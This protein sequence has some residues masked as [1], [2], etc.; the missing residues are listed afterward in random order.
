M[1]RSGR[2]YLALFVAN[3]AAV[4]VFWWLALDRSELASAAGA[5]NAAGRLAA[6]VGTYLLLVQLALR[7]HVPWLVAAF[8][9]DPLKRLHTWNAY[10]AV[11]LIAAHVVLQ[12][13]GYALQERLGLSDE[14][15]VMLGYE[16]LVPAIV[17]SLLLG[18]LTIVAL[19]RFRHQMAWPTWRA[20]HLFTY[21]AVALSI[22]HILATGS[23]FIDAPGWAAYW[24]AVELG[25]VVVLLAARVPPMWR[26]AAAAGRPHPAIVAVAAVV[27]ATY[28]FGTVRMTFASAVASPS[29]SPAGPRGTPRPSPST[30]ARPTPTGALAEASLVV[31]GEVIDT[32]YGPLQVRLV[33]AGGRVADV[34]PVM[35]PSA[36]KR[37]H[38]ISVSVEP[39]LRKRAVA[40]QSADFEILSGA[41]YTS[42]AY[43][44]SLES[45]LRASGLEQP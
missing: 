6:L 16:G 8:G 38:T 18:A 41:T 29:A 23:D 45:A 30:T 2:A 40:A 43:Q 39:W 42:R 14:I 19:D 27:L 13:A 17:G 35:L 28:L 10:L 34:E 11:G 25:V 9:K 44:A 3:L 12:I 24:V 20:L 1:T 5:L 32:P 15:A 36:T 7:T 26:A 31:Q 22:P 4:L 21:A 37:S 33:L